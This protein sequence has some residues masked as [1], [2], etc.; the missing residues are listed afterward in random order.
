MF[1]EVD[2]EALQPSARVAIEDALGRV[3]RAATAD[4]VEGIVGGSKELVETV[5]K[6]VINAL[7]D[8][9]GSNIDMP[10]LAHQT[11]AALELHPAGLQD[12]ASLR[13][14]SQALIS[15][16]G[17]LAELRNTDGTGHGRAAPSNLDRSHAVLAKDAATS[18]CRWLLA[19]TRR[20][21][22][23]RVPLDDVV[24]DIAGARVFSRGQLPAFLTEHQLPE[25]GEDDQRK[26]GL[27]VGRRWSVNGTFNV[28]I[29]VIEPLASGKAE[30]PPAFC[31][32]VLEGLLL[33][34]DGFLQMTPEDIRLAVG[35]G[36][37]L[38]GDRRDPVLKE[39]GD[40]VGDALLSYSFDDEAQDA[41]TA[42]LWELATEHEGSSL[43]EALEV[44]ARRIEE[45][46]EPDWDDDQDG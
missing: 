17:A 36:Q 46:R 3:E 29:D 43:G 7:G 44:I 8:T 5:A 22:K 26:L 39:L 11:V 21:L 24:T 34:Y 9:Y 25:L 15:M 45:L 42:E 30:Y 20:V 38:P 4:D 31:A 18:W 37:R 41:A 27:A 19:A 16:V 23:Q 13:K 12:R 2:L 32:G 40:R 33:D 6:A 14:L 28:R 10:K 1:D 35:I